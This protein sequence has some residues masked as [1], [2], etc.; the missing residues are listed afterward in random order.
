[1]IPSLVLVCPLLFFLTKFIYFIFAW[2][3]TV[4]V[5]SHGKE[6]RELPSTEPPHAT[7]PFP[8]APS[9]SGLWQAC[10]LTVLGI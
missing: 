6:E 10:R 2:F 5:C 7:V 9:S 3:M 4:S 8:Q 1:M